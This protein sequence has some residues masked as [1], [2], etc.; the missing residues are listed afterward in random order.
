MKTILTLLTA[1]LLVLSGCG[2][3]RGSGSGA[4][5]TPD[6]GLIDT[7]VIQVKTIYPINP[8][9]ATKGAIQLTAVVTDS[10]GAYLQSS[11][12][13]PVTVHWE[14]EDTTIATIDSNGKL[15]GGSKTGSTKVSLYAQYQNYKSKIKTTTVQ[16][17]EFGNDVAELHFS[18]DRA[19]I[20]DGQE[21][22]FKLTAVDYFGA[23]TAISPGSVSF[24]ISDTSANSETPIVELNKNVIKKDDDKILKVTGRNK[25][26]AFITPV[27]EISTD[28]NQ[29]TLKITGSP[30]IVQV[31]ESVGSSKPQDGNNNI[32]AGRQLSSSVDDVEGRKILHLMHYDQGSNR[33]KVIY[34]RFDGSWY[35]V[36][37]ADADR[38]S[39]VVLSPFPNNRS[40]PIILYMKDNRPGLTYMTANNQGWA[41]SSE[42]SPITDSNISRTDLLTDERMRILD[43]SASNDGNGSLHILYYDQLQK[44]IFLKTS[45]MSNTKSFNWSETNYSPIDIAT[46]NSVEDISLT[47]NHTSGLPRFA[48]TVLESN[49][50]TSGG[51]VW[52]ASLNLDNSTYKIG[53]EH[54]KGTDGTE[55]DVVLRLDG[56]NIP[57]IAWHNDHEVVLATRVLVSNTFQWVKNTISLLD[58]VPSKITGLDFTFD[59]YNSPR[60]SFS[61]DGEVKYV[62]RV[63]AANGSDRY[64][65][66][67]P[68]SSAGEFGA[69]TSV[70]VDTENR[71]HL[72]YTHDSDKWFGYWIEP[73]FFDYRVYPDMNDIKADVVEKK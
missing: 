68:E 70:S 9:V 56:N 6:G 41:L 45:S 19:Y 34:S 43:M 4:T 58:K 64:I 16:V 67:S 44:R 24:T 8:V 1:F 23:E 32:D 60:I 71:V 53:V 5:K 2:G 69:S 12:D 49:E 54:V 17:I 42:Y 38:A 40:F 72:T 47:N 35:S 65:I 48:Y 13:T 73:S 14:V 25:G 7:D 3:D 26:Y 37:V 28:N 61:A 63:S 31:K 15:I 51:G 22:S 39:K 62:R 21:R 33:K 27:Y 46:K 52:Y 29:T 59:A 50:S 30:L 20:D 36:D 18:P 10:T 57:T 55:K 11:L 66:E